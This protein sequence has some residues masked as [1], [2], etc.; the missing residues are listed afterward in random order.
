MS[1]EIHNRR[2]L[3]ACGPFG[4]DVAR[5]L[6]RFEQETGPGAGTIIRFETE[7]GLLTGGGYRPIV[8]SSAAPD[9]L[10]ELDRKGYEA[11]MPLERAVKA[12]EVV[13]LKARVG[14]PRPSR[15]RLQFQLTYNQG[16]HAKSCPFSLR[17][18]VPRSS[19]EGEPWTWM[20]R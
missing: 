17:I 11:S 12:G 9:L 2:V 7:I 19:Y 6:G 18:F 20:Y 14:A 10:L 8:E 16:H 4:M 5:L 1:Q 13:Q 15:H 3:D